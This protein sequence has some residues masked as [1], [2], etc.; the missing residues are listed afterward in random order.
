MF[1][2]KTAGALIVFESPVFLLLIFFYMVDQPTKYWYI[3]K[4]I[5]SLEFFSFRLYLQTVAPFVV[6]SHRDPVRRVD[7]NN[8]A[9]RNFGIPIKD[10]DVAIDYTHL[11]HSY[12]A[13]PNG[14]DAVVFSQHPFR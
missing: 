9:I 14:K 11:V 7:Q 6:I 13:D 12:F 2:L 1:S 4:F 8:V 3:F 5:H 10:C